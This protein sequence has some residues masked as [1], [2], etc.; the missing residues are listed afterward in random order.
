[1]N[2][3]GSLLNGDYDEAQSH[4]QFLEALNAWRTG[5]PTQGPKPKRTVVGA[6]YT[7]TQEKV[8]L[9]CMTVHR[10]KSGSVTLTGQGL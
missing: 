8:S 6:P 2:H 9:F 1:M 10:S 7:L 5:G 3:G 4:Q